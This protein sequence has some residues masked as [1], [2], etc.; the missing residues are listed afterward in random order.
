MECIVDAELIASAVSINFPPPIETKPAEA[1]ILGST[2]EEGR[3]DQIVAIESF[4]PVTRDLCIDSSDSVPALSLAGFCLFINRISI[5]MRYGRERL[6]G[7][8]KRV[9]ME[10]QI[11]LND[12]ISVQ[13]YRRIVVA[14]VLMQMGFQKAC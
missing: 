1:L 7:L 11:P 6:A 2:D 13:P 9:D 8:Q 4:A 10:L 3:F 5:R 14:Q 12:R